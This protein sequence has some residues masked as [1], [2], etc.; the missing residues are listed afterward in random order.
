MKIRCLIVDDEPLARK[1]LEKYIAAFSSLELVA[2]CTTAMEAL[3]FMHQHP[4]DLL[5]LDINMPEISGLEML[6]S[7]DRLPKVILTTA[8]SEYALESYEIGVVDYL[9]KPFSMERFTKAVNRV[10]E[11]YRESQ[12]ASEPTGTT[13]PLLEKL[14]LRQDQKTH[15]VD[16]SEIL[17]VQAFG[18]YLHVFTSEKKYTIREKMHVLEARLPAHAFL[19]VHKSYLVALQK[20]AAIEGNRIKIAAVEIPIG[21]YYK[22]QLIKKLE[23]Q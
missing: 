8:Y 6:K 23:S 19:R 11:S 7:L 2:Q 4:V 3:S 9:L 15:Y 5:F 12:R 20:I 13:P 18:N 10:M 21:N 17:Y 22:A 1:V 16:L 14:Q